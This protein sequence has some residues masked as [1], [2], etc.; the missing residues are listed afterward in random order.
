M[1]QIAHKDSIVLLGPTAS[2]KTAL[3]VALARHLDAEIISADSRQVYRGL[4]IGTGKDLSTYSSGG[5]P[6]KVHLLDRVDLPAEY[7]LFRY[8]RE[9]YQAMNDI[10][11]RDARALLCGGTGLY[12]DCLLRA[13]QLV[14]A[15]EDA[16]FRAAMQEME[17]DCLARTY[18]RVTENPHNITDMEDRGRLL[19]ALEIQA[20]RCGVSAIELVHAKGP[21]KEIELP[22]PEPFQA[23]ILG[24]DWPA[25]LLRERIGQRLDERL[26]EGM[27]DEVQ[28]LLDAGITAERLLRLGL[29]YRWV[30]E[31]LQGLIDFKAMRQGL[32]RAICEFARR[33]RMWFRR[34]ERKGLRIHWLNGEDADLDGRALAILNHQ[35]SQQAK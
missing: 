17:E 1:T 9:A 27:L 31:H 30:T 6:I 29:E 18:L 25:D 22:Q 12:L 2:G 7:H 26:R 35:W 33:Q 32:Y 20:A 23:Q 15:P 5:P 4:D 24:L 21:L 10:W 13:Y 8:Q 34:M 11:S 3:A 14:E 16:D 28:G 19:R